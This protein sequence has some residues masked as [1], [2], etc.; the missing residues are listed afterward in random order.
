MRHTLEKI[1]KYLS[2]APE[3]SLKIQNRCGKTYYYHQYKN[4][5]TGLYIKAYIDRKNEQFAR[6]LA[7]KGYYAKVKPL[8]EKKLQALET[9]AQADNDEEI[10]NVYD[11]LIQ[12]RKMLVVPIRISV[13][14]KLRIWQN[15]SY[16][17]Y[18]KYQEN[19]KYETDNG[20]LVRSKSEVII[21]NILAKNSEHLLYKYERPL[22]VMIAGHTQT[23]HPDFTIINIHTGKITYWEHAGRMD[24][25]KYADDFVK[26][27]NIYTENGLF[28]GDDVIVT[29]ETMNCP[30]N[31]HSVKMAVRRLVGGM[32]GIDCKK[33]IY[34]KSEEDKRYIDNAVIL[35]CETNA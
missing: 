12:E 19:L 30:L 32:D 8:I 18:Q 2:H 14:E 26:K 4:T 10:D 6:R 7:Q 20:E 31:I 35:E 22:E 33:L 3:G 23:I 25:A 28:Q 34:L 17:P 9:F 11:M 15:E 24:D 29:Y 21:A 5:E 13:N 16:E 1:E 27:M